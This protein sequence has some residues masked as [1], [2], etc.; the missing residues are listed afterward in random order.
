MTDIEGV[1][2]VYSANKTGVSIDARPKSEFEADTLPGSVNMKQ[3][4]AEA[5]NKDGRLPYT[6]HGTRVIVFGGSPVQGRQL[7]E[8]IAPRPYWNTS[9]FSGTYEELKKAGILK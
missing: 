2:K 7:A 3:G 5:A 8:E 4:E 6:D 1:K 9:Y